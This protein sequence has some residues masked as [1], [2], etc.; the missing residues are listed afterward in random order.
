M[1]ETNTTT[2]LMIGNNSDEK[3]NKKMAGVA[4]C[5]QIGEDY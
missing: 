3:Q 2:S 1:I 5:L 4:A